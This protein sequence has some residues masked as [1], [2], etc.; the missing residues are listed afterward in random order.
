[1]YLI[2]LNDVMKKIGADPFT[3]WLVRNL[4]KR[5]GR[6]YVLFILDGVLE[7]MPR[8]TTV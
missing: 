2:G 1:M 4:D 6:E 5:T 3:V 8:M 7:K